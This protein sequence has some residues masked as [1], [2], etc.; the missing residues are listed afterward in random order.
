MP[1][2]IYCNNKGCGK[3]TEPLLNI[4]TN[5]AECVECGAIINSVTS[6]AKTQMKTMGQIKRDDKKQQAFSVQCKFCKKS[7]LPEVNGKIVLCSLCKNEL[8]I[9]IHYANLIKD[10]LKK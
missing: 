3:N 7:V 8:N 1:F 5:E 2:M 10:K 9:S 6:F 4:E